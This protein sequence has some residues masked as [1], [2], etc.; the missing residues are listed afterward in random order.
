MNIDG[1][2]YQSLY[3]A[4][5]RQ[6]YLLEGLRMEFIRPSSVPF[7]LQGLSIYAR[8]EAGERWELREMVEKIMLD[9]GIIPSLPALPAMTKLPP[10]KAAVD[11]IPAGDKACLDIVTKI[12]VSD[13][14]LIDEVYNTIS[15][16]HSQTS[17]YSE[18]MPAETGEPLAVFD[19][20][21]AS[22]Y[23]GK[24]DD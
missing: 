4:L 18:E 14:Y 21:M 6:G 15:M 1:K 19:L 3:D 7:P 11:L 13:P 17:R 10:L 24:L 23:L 5:T 8:V 22:R 2:M 16:E 20:K 9:N 12:R